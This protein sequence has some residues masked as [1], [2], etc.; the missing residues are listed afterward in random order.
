[1]LVGA[2]ILADHPAEI[3]RGLRVGG[4]VGGVG[5]LQRAASHRPPAVRI[6]LLTKLNHLL[7]LRRGYATVAGF[8]EEDTRVVSE[9]DDCVA[10][11]LQALLPLPSRRGAFLVACGTDLPD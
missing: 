2:R 8:P 6:P 10:H 7:H 1:Q 11:H 9:I 5:A 3:L 4:V